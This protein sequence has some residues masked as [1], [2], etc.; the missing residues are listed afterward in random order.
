MAN[1]Q[2]DFRRELPHVDIKHVIAEDVTFSISDGKDSV[3]IRMNKPTFMLIAAYS[4][5]IIGK[6]A[7]ERY[8]IEMGI[9]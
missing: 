2:V 6:K 4:Y 1:T 9:D 7:F 5:Q 8:L 3:D